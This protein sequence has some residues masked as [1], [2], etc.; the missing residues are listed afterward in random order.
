MK[1]LLISEDQM[2]EWRFKLIKALAFIHK[3]TDFSDGDFRTYYENTHAPLAS[4]LLTFEGYVRNY[5]HSDFNP[6]FQS[7]GSISVFKYKSEDSLAIVSNQMS[8]DAGETLRKD[9]LNFMDVSKNFYVFTK[10]NEL[11][12]LTFKKK[13]FYIAKTQNELTHLDGMSG[14]VKIS[15]NLVNDH[16]SI[17]GIPEYGISKHATIDELEAITKGYPKAILSIANC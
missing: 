1:A 9:E 2:P 7:L 8:S 13:I 6:L 3:K 12:D 15:E 11:T 5:V 14:I 16:E 10:S 17:V 4:S